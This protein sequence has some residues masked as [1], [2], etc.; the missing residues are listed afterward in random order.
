MSGVL[1]RGSELGLTFVNTFC[2]VLELSGHGDADYATTKDA[3]SHGVACT[4]PQG[5]HAVPDIIY[6][7][8]VLMDDAQDGN[9]EERVL[10]IDTYTHICV[11]IPLN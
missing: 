4:F 3:S 11:W 2:C 8:H 7:S 6:P 9:V 5:N 1:D 10:D